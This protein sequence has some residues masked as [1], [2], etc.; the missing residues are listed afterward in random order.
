MNKDMKWFLGFLLDLV[1]FTILGLSLAVFEIIKTF[2]Y[3]LAQVVVM[4]FEQ[5]EKGQMEEIRN[6]GKW[7]IRYPFQ[8]IGLWLERIRKSYNR[9]SIFGFR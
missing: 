5:K 9:P 3:I 4:I 2:C 7:M 6:W 1:I 8:V